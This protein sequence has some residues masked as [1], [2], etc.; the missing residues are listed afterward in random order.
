MQAR[1]VAR[2]RVKSESGGPGDIRRLVA[3]ALSAVVP[4]LGQ[5]FNRDRRG[6]VAFALPIVALGLIGATI[7]AIYGTR[8]LPS[9][10]KPDA[11]VALLFLDAI[12]LGWRLI[13]VLH[14]FAGGGR[15]RVGG[16][17][18]IG[19][20]VVLALAAAPQ[21][22]AGFLGLRV[23]ETALRICPVCAGRSEASG[24]RPA[25]KP[26]FS[27]D[28]PGSADGPTPAPDGRINVLLLGVDNRSRSQGGRT[29]TMIVVSVDSVGRSASLLSI[30][31]DLVDVPLPGGGV[32]RDKIN[33]LL[34]HVNQHPDDPD[35]AWAGGSGTRALQDAL[36]EL[37]GI[38]IHYYAKVDLQGFVKVV[39]AVGGVDVKVAHT[40]DD[41]AYREFGIKG[42]HIEAGPQ[43]LDGQ[44][45]LAYARIRRP[46]G[47]SDF[48]R[49]ARQQQ[50]LVALKAAVMRG[51]A[52]DLLGRLPALLDAVAGA[53]RTDLPPTR[54]NDLVFLAEGIKGRAVVS[55]VLSAPLVSGRSNDP[56]GSVQV[57]HVEQIR[58]M[59][60][61]LFS[62]PGTPP[63]PWPTP[64]AKPKPTPGP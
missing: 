40:L 19:L 31:R 32:Y 8:L 55:V 52:L 30:P 28:D 37:L 7:G 26:L 22:Y 56:R 63:T 43:H 34:L 14:A 38:D 6:L 58:A 27:G 39:D 62:T 18:V 12:V 15:A 47:E 44:Y 53:V 20:V 59:A 17:G 5:A 35:F 11:I 61:L 3:A 51:G 64:K 10:L 54:Y 21:A 42:F 33:G 25:A 41:P 16:V 49:A 50:V 2:E 9:L 13:A 57:P 46:L 29:D 60:A 24:S 23:Y 36:G 48:T 45:A 1:P 4:G